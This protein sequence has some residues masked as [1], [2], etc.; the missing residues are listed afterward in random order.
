MQKVVLA[1]KSIIYPDQC[2]ETNTISNLL[3]EPLDKNDASNNIYSNNGSDIHNDFDINDGLDVNNHSHLDNMLNFIGYRSKSPNQ[4]SIQLTG[5][6]R[7]SQ[8]SVSI[9]TIHQK[10]R[11][12]QYLIFYSLIN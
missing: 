9:Q 8:S 3:P 11:L 10:N 2:P 12:I 4:A 6:N 7:N 1:I 5:S